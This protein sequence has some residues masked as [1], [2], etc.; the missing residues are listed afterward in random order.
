VSAIAALK[1]RPHFLQ[2]LIRSSAKQKS[3]FCV[4]GT[5]HTFGKSGRSDLKMRCLGVQALLLLALMYAGCLCA[6]QTDTQVCN[7]GDAG[8]H[9]R[10]KLEAGEVLELD[11]YGLEDFVAKHPAVVAAFC[12]ASAGKCKLLVPELAAAAKSTQEGLRIS[13][14]SPPGSQTIAE[15]ARSVSG[16][17]CNAR[18]GISGER[19]RLEAPSHCAVDMTDVRLGAQER[20]L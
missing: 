14:P 6:E 12:A 16:G 3:C 10:G 7:E 19:R 2:V 1:T 18:A 11:P 17:G 15:L 20:V 5:L 8:P 9:C 13:L 4:Q